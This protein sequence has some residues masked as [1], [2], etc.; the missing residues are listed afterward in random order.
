MKMKNKT[1]KAKNKKHIAKTSKKMLLFSVTVAMM[2]LLPSMLADAGHKKPSVETWKATRLGATSVQLNGYL[3]KTNEK[4][5]T[6]GE[7][8]FE[9]GT[10][11]DYGTATRHQFKKNGE[12]FYQRLTGL[13][14]GTYHYR[15]VAANSNEIA[16][17][18]DKTFI[19]YGQP[20][21]ITNEETRKG[22]TYVTLHGYLDYLG[23]SSY[24]QVWFE[25]GLS[26]DYG[27][28]TGKILKTS[29]G[30]FSI[31]VS[32]LSPGTTY[33]FRTAAF[34]HVKGIGIAYGEDNTFT[35]SKPK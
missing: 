17:G 35:T 24:C 14:P 12:S 13:S 8:W 22:A 25:Y 9:F 2:L 23:E 26:T 19:I 4:G 33:H 15:A 20:V 27:K 6:Q 5:L 11:T 30:S 18:R 1:N 3:I 34:N 31:Y 10:S 21:V 28:T 7:V 32:G 29:P 16:Y